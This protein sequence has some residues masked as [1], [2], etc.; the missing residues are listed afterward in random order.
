MAVVET[1]FGFHVMRVEA[2]YDAVS[3]GYLA[4]KI[5]PSEKTENANYDKAN[6]F[7]AEA[8]TSGI[9]KAAKT[10]GLKS[11]SFC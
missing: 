9:E 7:E 8:T 6:K 11:C 5:Q 1:D 4:L 2:K 3:L 10:S